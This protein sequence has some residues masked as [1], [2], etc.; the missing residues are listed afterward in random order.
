[1]RYL[2]LQWCRRRFP[3]L[4]A[5]RS[6]PS[7][8]SQRTVNP[9]QRCQNRRSLPRVPQSP[10]NR[11]RSESPRLPTLTRI[12]PMSLPQRRNSLLKVSKSKSPIN[13]RNVA[14]R[15]RQV[16]PKMVPLPPKYG[17]N[18]KPMMLRPQPQPDLPRQPS[19]KLS[20]SCMTRTF[21]KSRRSMPESSVL[22]KGRRPPKRI[23]TPH[24]ASD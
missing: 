2:S 9:N 20:S 19:G 6:H 1:M 22:K 14:A 4:V 18:W 15:P 3:P 5:A 16:V 24:L 21:L 11:S 7:Q 23:S 10:V 17:R 13:S 12:R 8:V